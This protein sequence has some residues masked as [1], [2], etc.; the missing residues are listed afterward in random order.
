MAGEAHVAGG[1][2][3]REHARLRGALGSSAS[4]EESGEREWILQIEKQRSWREKLLGW[5]KMDKDDACARYFRRTLENE[6]A[7]NNVSVE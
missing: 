7:F 1:A 4:E 3:S 5:A 6:P 2:P